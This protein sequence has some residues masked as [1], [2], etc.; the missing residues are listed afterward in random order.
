MA[1]VNEPAGQEEVI[2]EHVLHKLHQLVPLLID[3]LVLKVAW[4]DRKILE[5]LAVNSMSRGENATL[6]RV[7]KRAGVRKRKG[8][9]KECILR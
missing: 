5:H 8:A 6:K 7:E 4:Y 2:I 1:K 9:G 3:L